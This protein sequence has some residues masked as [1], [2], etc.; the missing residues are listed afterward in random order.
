MALVSLINIVKSFGEGG[1]VLRVL[2]GIT[3]DI[4][5][6]FIAILGP[7]GCGK[8]TLLRIIA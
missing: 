5:E 1:K 3:L 7:S 2:D 8:S 4:G 6:E